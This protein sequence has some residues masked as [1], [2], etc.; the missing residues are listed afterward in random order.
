ME[1]EL[2]GTVISDL[3]QRRAQIS[4][5]SH[6]SDHRVVNALVPLSE[7]VGYATTLRTLTHGTATFSMHV[8][9]YEAMS[10]LDEAKA[11]ERMTGLRPR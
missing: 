11:I 9:A 5:I 3:S 1:D 8:A 4:D 7:M 6:V 10:K 2:L